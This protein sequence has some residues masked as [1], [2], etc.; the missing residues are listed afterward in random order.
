MSRTEEDFCLSNVG[1]FSM[2]H[3]A[4]SIFACTF[5]KKR[6]LAS[7][8]GDRHSIALVLKSLPTD[9][10]WLDVFSQTETQSFRSHNCFSNFSRPW[11]GTK[12]HHICVLIPVYHDPFPQFRVATRSL[13]KMVA[14]PLVVW[15][16]SFAISQCG[17]LSKAM[18][19]VL[20]EM[21]CSSRSWSALAW[22]RFTWRN[23]VY[24][25][26]FLPCS[27]SK[28][29]CPFSEII[30]C[31]T[32]VTG[33]PVPLQLALAFMELSELLALM[34]PFLRLFLLY[35]FDFPFFQDFSSVI[36]G[37]F[38]AA[39]QELEVLAFASFSVSWETSSSTAACLLNILL[40]FSSRAL[41][42]GFWDS[43][44]S[45]LICIFM[46]WTM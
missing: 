9:N 41:G 4:Q 10:Y 19:T 33:C 27:G 28:S 23:L 39:E 5:F 44:I 29:P 11:F 37:V 34:P 15:V 31:R 43:A 20:S 32:V 3:T 1:I 21:V 35:Q 22:F 8:V 36:L 42:Q 40:Y 6:L 2:L 17:S 18:S 46:G 26:C 24:C 25:F 12:Q 38:S 45:P 7:V 13:V 14:L 30:C 16:Q